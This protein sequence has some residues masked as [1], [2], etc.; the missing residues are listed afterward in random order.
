MLGVGECPEDLECGKDELIKPFAVLLGLADA[1]EAD[2]LGQSTRDRE[3]GC[4]ERRG[5]VSA[6]DAAINDLPRAF[7]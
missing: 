5:Q 6:L 2:S 4:L 7:F 1:D 3:V